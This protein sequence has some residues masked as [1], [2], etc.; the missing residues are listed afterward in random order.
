MEDFLGG[1][2]SDLPGMKRQEANKHLASLLRQAWN[3]RMERA[4]F[5][6]FEMSSRVLAWF[7]PHSF[8]DGDKVAFIDD[9]GKRRRKQLVGW[10]ERR[11]IFWH[12]A[13]EAKPVASDPTRIVLR[14]HVIFTEDGKTPLYSKQRMHILRRS[15]CKSWWNDRWRDLLL[16]FVQLVADDATINLPVGPNTSF[17]FGLPMRLYSKFAPEIEEAVTSEDLDALDALNLDND[18]TEELFGDEIEQVG[19]EGVPDEP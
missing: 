11:Q 2:S 13:F 17:A 18:Y 1:S 15:F 4:G 10:S 14:P 8:A 12:A 9:A 5:I 6:S 7:P 16:A 19:D 3:A